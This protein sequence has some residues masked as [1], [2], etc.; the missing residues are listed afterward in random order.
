M[1]YLLFYV[2]LVL[3]VIQAGGLP[4]T[5]TGYSVASYCGE[6]WSCTAWNCVNQTHSERTC[7]DDKICDTTIHKPVESRHDSSCLSI[8]GEEVIPGEVTYQPASIEEEKPE[9]ENPAE[10]ER[11][12][13]TSTGYVVARRVE[14]PYGDKGASGECADGSC[15]V[16]VSFDGTEIPFELREQITLED[17]PCTYGWPAHQGEIVVINEENYAC[18]LFEVTDPSLQYSAEEALDCCSVGCGEGCHDFCGSAHRHSGIDGNSTEEGLKRCAGLYIIY[19]LGPG[20][21]W[22]QDYFAPEL[23]CAGDTTLGCSESDQYTCGC[24]GLNFSE[25]AMNLPCTETAQQWVSDVDMS[26]NSCYL[27]DLPAH[28]T[29]NVLSTGTCVDYS[30][31]VT[32]LLRL[33]GYGVDEVYSVMGPGHEYNLVKFPGE[34]NWNVVDTNENNPRP[35]NPSGLPADHYSYCDY[36]TESCANDAGQGN[37]PPRKRVKGCTT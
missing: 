19:G 20:R 11:E 17:S 14:K 22:V 30:V 37:C 21:K 2:V 12:E 6:Q 32:T 13:V 15:D 24:S 31:S 36:L 34:R 29:L 10:S 18:D 7:T 4:V 33:V 28:V 23:A 27:S 16:E 35:Y 8:A 9:D 3:F 1:I 5:L 26:K 25:N